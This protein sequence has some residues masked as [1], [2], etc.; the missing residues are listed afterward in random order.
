[1][2]PLLVVL[3]S[4]GAALMLAGCSVWPVS[5][6]SVTGSGTTAT[7]SYDLSGFTGLRLDNSCDATVTR[8][9]AFAVDV[10]VD[11]NLVQHLV[12]EVKGDTL[13][14]GLDPGYVYV[15]AHLS[16]RVTMPELETLELSGAALAD[17]SGFSSEAPLEFRL[18]GASKLSLSGVRCGDVSFDISGASSLTGRL[19]SQAFGGEVSGAGDVGL[20]G[21]GTTLKVE[22]SGASDV[23]LRYFAVQDADVTLSGASSGQVRVSGTLNVDASGASQL[24]YFGSPTLGDVNVSGG[25]E[26]NHAAD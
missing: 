3:L 12:V 23:G 24:D 25:S 5:A 18:S 22:G 14:I 16:A 2:L 8:G 17:V 20:E 4:A 26:V 6:G 11:D 21:S 9:D 7:K 10:S 1:V 19:E 15:N 13:H